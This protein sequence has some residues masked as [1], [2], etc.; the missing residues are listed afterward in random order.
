M[1]KVSLNYFCL[2]A[3]GL[4]PIFIT[5]IAAL[6]SQ[7]S[8]SQNINICASVPN[9]SLGPV[10]YTSGY[11]MFSANHTLTTNGSV[12]LGGSSVTTL[13]GNLVSIQPGFVATSAG[14]AL[15][16]VRSSVCSSPVSKSVRGTNSEFITKVNN[17]AKTNGLKIYPNPFSQKFI[18]KLDLAKAMQVSINVYDLAGRQLKLI[19]KSFLREGPHQFTTDASDLPAGIYIVVCQAE[20]FRQEQKITKVN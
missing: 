14:G 1:K 12:H 6:A 4:L 10:T 11:H 13:G 5:A 7:K 16:L 8:F 9:L 15:I 2:E 20:K 17:N 3:W 18:I 19:S